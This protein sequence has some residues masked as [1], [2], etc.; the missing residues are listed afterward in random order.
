M[1]VLPQHVIPGLG[2]PLAGIHAPASTPVAFYGPQLALG[3]RA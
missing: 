2:A 1:N 3:R